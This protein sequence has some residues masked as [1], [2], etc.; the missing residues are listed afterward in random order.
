[1]CERGE[2]NAR[3][4]SGE[5]GRAPSMAN[6]RFDVKVDLQNAPCLHLGIHASG[7]PKIPLRSDFQNS[8]FRIARFRTYLPSALSRG[9]RLRDLIYNE[10]TSMSLSAGTRFVEQSPPAAEAD[11]A[12]AIRKWLVV[13]VI[14]GAGLR[15]DSFAMKSRLLGRTGSAAKVFLYDLSDPARLSRATSLSSPVSGPSSANAR[16]G[17]REDRR[18]WCRRVVLQR[19]KNP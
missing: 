1:V 18:Q 5:F 12:A 11:Q 7:D 14:V 13:C 2:E 9:L 8:S 3:N 17:C 6:A 15:R 10:P 4:S 19:D 16:N